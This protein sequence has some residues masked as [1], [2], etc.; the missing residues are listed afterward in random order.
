LP[1]DRGNEEC[2]QA[3]MKR[4]EEQAAILDMLVTQLH[5]LNAK[6]TT[7]N[8]VA[9]P[10]N[11]DASPCIGLQTAESAYNMSDVDSLVCDES[12]ATHHSVA[13]LG[14]GLR[15]SARLQQLVRPKSDKELSAPHISSFSRTEVRTLSKY[16]LPCKPSPQHHD[17]PLEAGTV[18]TPG[19]RSG[20]YGKE[21]FGKK[22]LIEE[23][24]EEDYNSE[25]KCLKTQ[26]SFN[27]PIGKN[28][29]DSWHALDFDEDEH[30]VW[31]S[32]G[33]A[34]KIR[35][36]DENE[37]EIGNRMAMTRLNRPKTCCYDESTSTNTEYLVTDKLPSRSPVN[38]DELR[39]QSS[40]KQKSSPHFARYAAQAQ[41]MRSY[42]A[43]PDNAAWSFVDTERRTTGIPMSATTP[44]TSGPRYVMSTWS[45]ATLT[46]ATAEQDQVLRDAMSTR[47]SVSYGSILRSTTGRE[48]TDATSLMGDLN[49]RAS[50]SYVRSSQWQQPRPETAAWPE[51]IFQGGR[52]KELVPSD[53]KNRTATSEPASIIET[54][55]GKSNFQSTKV[56]VSSATQTNK[57]VSNQKL[58]PASEPSGPSDKETMLAAKNSTSPETVSPRASRQWIKLGSYNG[59]TAVEAF[60]KKF[61]VCARNNSWT[62]DEKLNQLMCALTEPANQL[63]WEFDSATVVTW[64][65]LIQRLRQRYGG[66]DQMTLYQTQ[67]S[68]RRQ[69]EGEDLG[70]LVQDIR[71]LMSLAF[72]GPTTVYRE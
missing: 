49:L 19:T 52:A 28:R 35:M 8:D 44:I 68:T 23:I 2:W 18:A 33:Y 41:D 51:Q 59:R 42:Y 14:G 62:D 32:E 39:R 69:K 16:D 48:V 4:Q 53:D 45:P 20:V 3:I 66:T 60:I 9:E 5:L 11:P 38:E 65:D 12:A 67:L 7:D 36:N 30:E 55:A 15:R 57:L 47:P 43:T 64:S 1:S 34:H 61:E 70:V 63:L 26:M 29:V 31:M 72:L 54:E 37:S 56:M 27:Q 10:K 40:Y 13:P 6:L 50:K 25:D 58:P 46:Y 21:Y 17:R 22:K 24:R 71:K